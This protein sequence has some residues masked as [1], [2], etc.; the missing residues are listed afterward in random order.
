MEMLEINKEQQ[1]MKDETQDAGLVGFSLQG[2]LH[3]PNVSPAVKQISDT[4]EFIINTNL[5]TDVALLG[6]SRCRLRDS[7]G[8]PW[9]DSYLACYQ[10][11]DG[12][13]LKMEV[14]EELYHAL[15]L[16]FDTILEMHS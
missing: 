16:I 5:S 13:K 11:A 15:H 12:R 8:Y 2:D 6:V 1:I 4:S 9:R 10:L 14:N 7:K 3:F